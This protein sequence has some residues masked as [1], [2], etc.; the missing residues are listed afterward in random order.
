MLQARHC[1]D[2]GISGDL[3]AQAYTVFAAVGVIG[4]IVAGKLGD[5]KRVNNHHIIQLCMLAAGITNCLMPEIK[6]FP[7]IIAYVIVIG[8]A[9]GA[10]VSLL[11]GSI[12]RAVG[13]REYAQAQGLLMFFMCPFVAAG[14]AISG[15]F[16]LDSALIQCEIKLSS[17]L[18]SSR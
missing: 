13:K 18:L 12:S 2:I 7:V 17:G 14:P 16:K 5:W 15:R 9:C 6:T 11:P 8:V 3:S 10:V 1:L 4:R